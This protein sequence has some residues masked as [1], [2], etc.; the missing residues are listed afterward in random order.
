MKPPVLFLKAHGKPREPDP[1]STLDRP[2]FVGLL[3]LL[4][5]VAA[6]GT[7]GKH[8]VN[9]G[10]TVTFAAGDFAGSGQ[11]T[12]TGEHG[13]TVLDRSGREHRVHWYEITAHQVGKKVKNAP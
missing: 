8:N 4:K 9:A 1:A 3:A 11:V 7:F 5:G 2:H 13:A 12:A 10:D 6:G